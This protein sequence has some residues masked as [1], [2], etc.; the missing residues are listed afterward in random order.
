MVAGFLGAVSAAIVLRQKTPYEILA[1]IVV[2][3]ISAIYFGPLVSD[4]LVRILGFDEVSS[5]HI[6]N[7]AAFICGL[8]GMS[9]SSGVIGAAHTWID[10]WVKRKQRT[11]D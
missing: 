5:H 1:T 7:A 3:V 8:T 6:H 4:W 11:D 9:I 10:L 2:G